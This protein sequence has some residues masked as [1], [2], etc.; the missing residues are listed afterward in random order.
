MTTTEHPPITDTDPQCG[1]GACADHGPVLCLCGA[2]PHDGPLAD[3]PEYVPT[4]NAPQVVH[5]TGVTYRE[6]DYWTRV[7]LI[8]PAIKARGSGTV[9]RYLGAELDTAR[10][11]RALRDFEIGLRRAFTI[12]RA[13]VARDEYRAVLGDVFELV[14]RVR[15]VT[16]DP[17]EKPEAQTTVQQPMCCACLTV[18]PAGTIHRCE[19]QA[20]DSEPPTT[21][22]TPA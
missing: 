6:W 9:R 12:A 16:S 22:G 14:V 18:Y 17:V 19:P 4:Y 21:E 11:V 2:G 15:D 8:Q 3:C 13:V 10:L 7:G 1:S 5:L 20:T